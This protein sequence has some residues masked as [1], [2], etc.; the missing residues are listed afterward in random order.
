[1]KRRTFLS[2]IPL[3]LLPTTWMIK[4]SFFS[5]NSFAETSSLDSPRNASTLEIKSKYNLHENPLGPPDE[6]KEILKSH[7]ETNSTYTDH[8]LSIGYLLASLETHHK[9]KQGFIS[10][11]PGSR[12][13]IRQILQCQTFYK[14]SLHL[15][16]YEYEKTS[17]A[18]EEYNYEIV[19]YLP[20]L[21][22]QIDL[23]KF[24]TVKKGI[25]YFSNPHLPF[26]GFY[27]KS[28]LEEF[29][30]NI[31][32]DVLVIVDECYI[33]YLGEDWEKRSVVS[34]TEKFKNLIVLRTFSK[35]YGM[36]GLRLGYM[37]AHPDTQKLISKNIDSEHAKVSA[38]TAWMG[39]A[40]IKSKNHGTKTI[41]INNDL[42]QIIES[43]CLDNKI[44]FTKTN[45]NFVCFFLKSKQQITKLRELMAPYYIASRSIRGKPYAKIS[46][47]NEVDL[48]KFLEQLGKVI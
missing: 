22:N 30:K 9:L 18:G 10:V 3:G 38:L 4:S 15:C 6:C 14:K 19:P 12:E 29:V 35:F 23:S 36:S 26:G 44:E 8:S 1:M 33:Q 45:A 39:K 34:L 24:Q 20:T 28:I 46:L 43:F 41:K 42:K 2:A 13:C 11:A 21:S 25:V 40:A 16:K 31:P 5:W 32:S 17:E 37:I 7:F 27:E 48:K 47:K